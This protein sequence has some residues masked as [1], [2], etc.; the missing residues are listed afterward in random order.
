MSA[1]PSRSDS[2]LKRCEAI[3]LQIGL[4]L[5]I[6]LLLPKSAPHTEKAHSITEL[7]HEDGAIPHAAA[8]TT[9]RYAVVF[10][11][12]STGSRVHIFKFVQQ[13]AQGG[14]GL[15]LISDTFEQLKP[16][17]SSFPDDPGAAALSLKPLIDL[18]LKT[19]PSELQVCL[20]LS[21]DQRVF[22]CYSGRGW[23]GRTPLPKLCA[24]QPS[25]VGQ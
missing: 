12:G 1:A 6:L 13:D 11:A 14:G 18:A 25:S 22:A 8:A 3:L 2:S 17:L 9:V 16:G 4:L 7:H 23:V 20:S 24:Y 5:V 10:D 15:K 21:D 19:V